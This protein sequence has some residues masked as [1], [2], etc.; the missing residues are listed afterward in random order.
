[1]ESLNFQQGGII[2]KNE[3]IHWNLNLRESLQ[4]ILDKM[5]VGVSGKRGILAPTNDTMVGDLK[6]ELGTNQVGGYNTVKIAAG[7][8]MG[9]TEEAGVDIVIAG[10]VA[11]TVNGIP[12]TINN[13]DRYDPFYKTAKDS[14]V[15]PGIAGLGVGAVRYVTVYPRIT[16]FEEGVCNISTSNQVVF[17]DA[18]VVDKLRDHTS[19]SPSKLKFFTDSATPYNSSAVYEVISIVDGTAII[20]SGS[21]GSAVTG[22][23]CAIVGSYDLQEMAALST[24]NQY[25]Y[26]YIK[27]EVVIDTTTTPTLGGFQ[28]AMLNFAADHSFTIRDL[29]QDRL[30]SLGSRRNSPWAN[31][32]EYFGESGS[33][34][35][36]ILNST[37]Y[38]R[39]INVDGNGVAERFELD[40]A[41]IF[42]T[43]ASLSGTIP[44]LAIIPTIGSVSAQTEIHTP[45]S[46]VDVTAIKAGSW[47][48][49]LMQ[50][51][52]K[53]A[54]TDGILRFFYKIAANTSFNSGNP[55]R[56][57]IFL[58]K[59]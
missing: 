48:T 20:I 27:G 54:D 33:E 16:V 1:M 51:F 38:I 13:L 39:G 47:A 53:V 44:A 5:C 24:S 6:V 56:F 50:I 46:T 35:I 25:L 8:G 23:Y 49:N 58:N 2:G 43:G 29:R 45:L 32:I 37:L 9:F 4:V 17:S 57:H 15:I 11:T 52:F 18:K 28:V 21:F 7:W 30:F 59:I 40:G 19:N 26:G 31:F 36:D 10:S 41:I 12:K 14:I 42:K 3:L 55:Y 34:D 22:L